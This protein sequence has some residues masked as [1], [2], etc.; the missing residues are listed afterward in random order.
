MLKAGVFINE[1]LYELTTVSLRLLLMIY[2]VLIADDDDAR[3]KSLYEQLDQFKQTIVYS[4]ELSGRSR[5][6][7]RSKYLN[8]WDLDLDLL[9]IEGCLFTQGKHGVVNYLD[10]QSL[11]YKDNF[12]LN[13]NRPLVFL[14]IAGYYFLAEEMLGCLA[15]IVSRDNCSLANDFL[16]S[17]LK[18]TLD[19]EGKLINVYKATGGLL[20]S[21]LQEDVQ[22][23]QSSMDFIVDFKAVQNAEV[24]LCDAGVNTIEEQVDLR[25]FRAVLTLFNLTDRSGGSPIDFQGLVF[26]ASNDAKLNEI[27]D[28]LEQL[29]EFASHAAPGWLTGDEF[30]FALVVRQYPG[31]CIEWRIT[32]NF[33][34]QNDWVAEFIRQGFNYS[35][36]TV[37][38]LMSFATKTVNTAEFERQLVA[39]F[40]WLCYEVLPA[41][42]M[43][44]RLEVNKEISRRLEQLRVA[45]N[46]ESLIRRV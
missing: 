18:M 39:L 34:H 21:G 25:Q 26:G 43:L 22:F 19:S 10:I 8:H 15:D 30:F 27:L 16:R 9:L 20:F 35:T 46:V 3:I 38:G 33:Q 14:K 40:K 17:N 28:A 32:D 42:R 45:G 1:E 4:E 11:G 6:V 36:D 13:I 24:I 7:L 12:K 5:V 29:H 23:D 2:V 41:E 31:C 37:R 44:D